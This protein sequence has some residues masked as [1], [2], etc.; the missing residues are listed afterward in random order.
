MTPTIRQP[1]TIRAARGLVGVHAASHLRR[2]MVELDRELLDHAPELVRIVVH[3]LFHFV[4]QR[5]DNATRAAWSELLK[6]EMRRRVKGE[7]GWS[8]EMRKEK[9][10]VTGNSPRRWRDYS[11]E[12]FCDTAAWYFS[13]RRRHSEFTLD[14]RARPVRRRWFDQL[15]GSRRLPV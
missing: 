10:G 7:L 1:L 8:A 9:L 2:R 5:L 13:P 3:E 11:C 12:S 15:L 14:R 6:S 4:W